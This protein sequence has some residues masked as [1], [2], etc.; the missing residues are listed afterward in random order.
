MSSRVFRLLWSKINHECSWSVASGSR[1]TIKAATTTTMLTRNL[2]QSQVFCQSSGKHKVGIIQMT[3][4]A[5]KDANFEIAA[6]LIRDAKSQGSLVTET[7]WPAYFKYLSSFFNNW[8]L[9]KDGISSRSV[10]LHRELDWGIDQKG[11]DFRGRVYQQVSEASSRAQNMDIYRK[12]S[13]KS[14]TKL[15]KN[16]KL[17]H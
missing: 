3:C 1:T 14:N 12:L 6:K 11:R 17:K 13:S 10:R 7:V 16:K 2:S 9:F 4:T 15:N 5:D 8:V